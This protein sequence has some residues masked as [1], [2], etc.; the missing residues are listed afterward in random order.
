MKYKNQS[1]LY[2]QNKRVD[3][4]NRVAATRG[5]EVGEGKTRKEINCM[6]MNVN[7][8]SGG[9]HAVVYAKF[10]IYYCIHQT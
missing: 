5:K 6:V 3:A 7:S 8:N 4:E 9:E 10:E 1:K 2:E